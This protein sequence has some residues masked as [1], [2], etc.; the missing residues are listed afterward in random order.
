MKENKNLIAKQ[1]DILSRA[2]HVDI[3]FPGGAYIS[4][5][6]YVGTTIV[7]YINYDG[8]LAFG[9]GHSFASRLSGDTLAFFNIHHMDFFTDGKDVSVT[10]P[11]NATLNYPAKQSPAADQ[12]NHYERLAKKIDIS[13]AAEAMM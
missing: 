12:R 7:K 9:T 4:N 3:H 8:K 5:A 2:Y 13:M 11:T 1:K 10:D 6:V